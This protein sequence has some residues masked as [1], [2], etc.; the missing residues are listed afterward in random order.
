MSRRIFEQFCVFIA[1]NNLYSWSAGRVIRKQ[2][3]LRQPIPF[4]GRER[5]PWMSLLSRAMGKSTEGRH[6]TREAAAMQERGKFDVI[7]L[8]IPFSLTKTSYVWIP[9]S[10]SLH[11][12]PLLHLTIRRKRC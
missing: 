11:T 9:A 7:H 1:K 8:R 2:S 6:M 10:T 4:D 12:Y 5:A 3:Y